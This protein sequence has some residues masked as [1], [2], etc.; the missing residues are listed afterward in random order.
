VGLLLVGPHRAA[1]HDQAGEPA[2]VG[3]R[4]ALVELHA[5][6]REPAREQLVLERRR[7]LALDVLDG[8]ERRA[9]A[10]EAT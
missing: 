7:R 2:P 10:R 1:H 5:L 9:H 3:Q 8:E 6:E 4:I